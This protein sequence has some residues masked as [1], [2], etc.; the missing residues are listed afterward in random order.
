MSIQL[1]LV[2]PGCLQ[3]IPGWQQ[4][5]D[6]LPHAPNLTRLLSRAAA[7]P[8]LPRQSTRL[9]CALCDIHVPT[10][11][12]VPLAA[13]SLLHENQDPLQAYWLRADPV[14]FQADRDCVWLQSLE[15]AP[16][17]VEAADALVQTCA[18]VMQHW[19]YDLIAPDPSRWYV[20]V[21]EVPQLQTHTLADACGLRADTV[22]PTGRDAKVWRQL[23]NELQMLLH[24]HPVN[25]QRELEGL[26]AVNSLWF[27]GGGVCPRTVNLPWQHIV[28]NEPYLAGMAKLGGSTYHALPTE[29]SA[30]WPLQGRVLVLLPEAKSTN[31]GQNYD[32]WM[33]YW[34]SLE[35]CWFE[36]LQAALKTQQITDVTLYPLSGSVYRM[37]P[38]QRFQFWKRP[39]PLATF[40]T[41]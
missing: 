18:P 12:D 6:L 24:Q 40:L 25:E 31:P 33:D 19:G 2:I 5:T 39:Q 14:L 17:S 7:L 10:D 36:P 1:T 22:M 3:G 37:T 28:S 16:L 4:H 38:K 26:P 41:A 27:W 20:R 34:R 23:L 29:L 9:L 15:Q 8:N 11:E 32:A 21:P 35:A 30:L 13:L